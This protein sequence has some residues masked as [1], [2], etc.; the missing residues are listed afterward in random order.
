M[1]D[2]TPFTLLLESARQGDQDASQ[3]LWISVYDEVRRIA[4]RAVDRE[5]GANSLQATEL[6]HEA[7]ATVARAIR[8]LL[9][10]R[11]RARKAEK[12]GGQLERVALDEVLDSPTCDLPILLD[13]D[14]ALT[15]LETVDKRCAELVELR[16]FSGMT[17]EQA[18]EVLSVSIRTAAG[19]WAFARAW[20]RRSLEGEKS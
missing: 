3:Q 8:R 13:L 10:D 6:A 4:Q 7:L 19:D 14:S 18:A 2:Y 20:L 12:R 17:L 1:T 16:F 15:E 9:V 11:A 5:F